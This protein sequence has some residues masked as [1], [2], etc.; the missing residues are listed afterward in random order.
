MTVPDPSLPAA[1]I[2]IQG[3]LATTVEVPIGV[4]L[5]L[6]LLIVLPTGDIIDLARTGMDVLKRRAMTRADDSKRPDP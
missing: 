6:F 5:L 3:F 4:L 1:A 2:E